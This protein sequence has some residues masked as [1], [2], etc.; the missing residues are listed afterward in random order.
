MKLVDGE[1]HVLFPHSPEMFIYGV[2]E[3]NLKRSF[4]LE[5]GESYKQILPTKDSQSFQGFIDALGSSDYNNFVYSNGFLL[6]Q[7]SGFVPRDLL[8]DLPK[9]FR[10]GSEYVELAN[11]YKTKYKYQIFKDGKKLWQGNWDVNLWSVKDLLFSTS[12]PGEDPDAVEK[13]VQTFYFYELR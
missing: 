2:P 10:G 3:L 12:K 13:D 1:L 5:P 4:S 7:F 11:K 9:E 6:T 8:D